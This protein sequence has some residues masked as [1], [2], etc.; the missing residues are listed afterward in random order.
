MK[1]MV[2]R[3]IKFQITTHLI[4][5]PRRQAVIMIILIAM[6][7]HITNM[8]T[9]VAIMKPIEII[10]LDEKCTPEVIMTIKIY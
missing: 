3:T 7:H 9:H 4:N 2:V 5:I 1:I 6:I 8:V 10:C